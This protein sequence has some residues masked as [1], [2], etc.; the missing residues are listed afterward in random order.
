MLLGIFLGPSNLGHEQPEFDWGRPD[1]DPPLEFPSA[2][3]LQ[4]TS[5]KQT[6]ETMANV[7]QKHFGCFDSRDWLDVVSGRTES[8][9]ALGKAPYNRRLAVAM[10]TDILI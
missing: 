7:G 4:T 2:V 1:F 3:L 5:R 8:H 10:L 6:E 9:L